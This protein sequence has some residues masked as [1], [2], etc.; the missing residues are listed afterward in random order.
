MDLCADD[1]DGGGL[2]KVSSEES[3]EFHKGLWDT[4]AIQ[5]IKMR[6]NILTTVLLVLACFLSCRFGNRKVTSVFSSAEKIKRDDVTLT[7]PS[8]LKRTVAG[9]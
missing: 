9:R 8:K 2:E 7:S 1:G 4:G 6:K 3:G 5:T